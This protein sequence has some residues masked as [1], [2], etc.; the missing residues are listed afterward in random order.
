[1]KFWNWSHGIPLH[2]YAIPTIIMAIAALVI[3]LA[4]YLKSKKREEEAKK[5]LE[6]KLAEP[7]GSE[8]AG[9]AIPSAAQSAES[10]TVDTAK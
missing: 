8:T 3:I 10:S 5:Q 4:H 7:N 1:M 2:V 9:E 6:E